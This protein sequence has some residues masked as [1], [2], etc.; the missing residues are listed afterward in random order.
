MRLDVDAWW[1]LLIMAKFATYI[2]DPDLESRAIKA[3]SL[4]EGELILRGVSQDQIRELE[5]KEKF[6]LIS[7]RVTQFKGPSIL[8]DEN[9]EI[10]E[11]VEKLQPAKKAESFIFNKKNARVVCFFGLGGGNG[12]STLALNYA[13]EKAVSDQV[14]LLD[15]DRRNPDLALAL[16]LHRIDMRVERLS[17]NL[18]VVQGVI[19][20]L[21]VDLY[22]C[23]LGS[24]A[25]HPMLNFADD[26]YVVTR[27]GYNTLARL[28]SLTIAP[29]AI[30]FNFHERSKFQLK[31]KDLIKEEFPRMRLIGVPSDL[32]SFE[33]AAMRKS[34]L[35]EVAANSQA[36]KAIATLG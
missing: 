8:I 33:T 26:I 15:L 17:K 34:A 36:R 1:L 19:E 23:D 5:L 7:N 24:E 29:T 21:T 16:G 35:F 20:D 2:A 28:K 27:L 32:K 10:E 22:V 14:L 25:G 3:I 4:A 11:L 12:T 31:I 9:L 13:F 6:V 30:I 18:S